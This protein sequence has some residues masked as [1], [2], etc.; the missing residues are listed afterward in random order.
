MSKP[1]VRWVVAAAALLL[2]QSSVYAEGWWSDD[3]AFRKEIGFDLTPTA[4]DVSGDQTDV[5]VLIRLSVGNFAF[6]DDAKPDG[7]DLRFIA[8]D[9]LTPLEFH[10]ERYDAQYQLALIWVRVPLVTGG[11]NTDRIHMYYGN[12]DAVSASNPEGVYDA[13]QTLLIQ[14]SE[15]DAVGDRTAYGNGA[16]TNTATI[17]E[18]G[19]IAGAAAFDTE[20][21]LEVP[22]SATLAVSSESG[23]TLSAWLRLAEATTAEAAF[24]TLVDP[25]T[26]NRIEV[27]VDGDLP[28]LSAIVDSVVSETTATATLTPGSWHHLSVRGDADGLDLLID[29]L[30]TATLPVT[31]LDY[32]AT[33][34]V[35]ATALNPL[36]VAGDVDQIGFSTVARTDDR[37]RFAARNEAAFSTL[38]VYGADNSNDAGAAGGESYFATTL[39]NVTVDGWVVIVILMVMA[40]I[41]WIVMYLKGQLLTRIERQN[42]RF[43]AEYSKLVGDPLA[44]DRDVP[45]LDAMEE[46]SL[47]SSAL[48]D[49]ESYHPS[50]LFP[51]YHVGSM[52]VKKRIA[53][54]SPAVGAAASGFT[55]QTIGAIGASIDA[56]LVRQRQ[57]MNRLM[58]LLTIAIS[59]G[60]FLG[61][62]GTVIGVMITFAAIAAS[63]DVNVNSIAPGIAAALVATVAGLVVAIPALFGYNWLGSRIKDIDANT[64][65]FADEFINKI[66]E[67][68]N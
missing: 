15:P 33:L 1:I 57:K 27:T 20:T 12:P 26:G 13:L 43:L 11:A 6:F 42:T 40:V 65:V 34:R 14:F 21:V 5:P 7:S 16:A 4:G 55:A 29:G 48:E 31:G 18:G 23:F 2:F 36:A 66:A 24:V 64:Q 22:S 10:I 50:T 28:S 38:V 58:V 63:G 25:I 8:S 60:P 59:G 62:L 41:S 45:E 47:L 39:R 19:L 44:L 35:G 3:W 56:A 46:E 37:I 51:L 53:Q 30:P 32:A 54:Q 67:H 17:I 61:L 52:E 9:D 49:P 68:Y